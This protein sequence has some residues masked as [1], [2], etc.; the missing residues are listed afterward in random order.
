MNTSSWKCQFRPPSC[1]GAAVLGTTRDYVGSKH[2]GKPG[3]RMRESMG[4][5]HLGQN[6]ELRLVLDVN[7]HHCDVPA[8]S[9]IC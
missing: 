2:E 1:D 6:G 4:A 3:V 8:C 7:K 5:P 9:S